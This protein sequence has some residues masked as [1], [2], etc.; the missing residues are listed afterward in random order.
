MTNFTIR[1]SGKK[2]CRHCE[3]FRAKSYRIRLKEKAVIYKGNACKN[4]GY[5]K[6]LRALDFHHRDPSQKDF[7][8]GE[9][10]QGKKIV[11]SWDALIPELDKCDLLCKNCHAE[12]H[13]NT[14]SY[15]IETKFK[16][17]KKNINLINMHI[18]EG[19]Y[20]PEQMMDKINQG[21]YETKEQMNCRE[22][23]HKQWLKEN[24][25]T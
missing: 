10:R 21:Q 6:S 14:D 16:I 8:I 4:C 2:V 19:R 20:T 9:T 25:R 22:I 7:A 11:R 24:N 5:N 3:T 18:I 17:H 1:K 12:V 13:E 23:L 15:D